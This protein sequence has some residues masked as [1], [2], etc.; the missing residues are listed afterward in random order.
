MQCRRAVDVVRAPCGV[1]PLARF[2]TKPALTGSPSMVHRNSP[3]RSWCAFGTDAALTRASGSLRPRLPYQMILGGAG[4]ADGSPPPDLFTLAVAVSHVVRTAIPC[5]SRSLCWNMQLL[6]RDASPRA[7]NS[8]LHTGLGMPA[9][10]SGGPL[11]HGTKP[12]SSV[13]LA[14]TVSVRTSPSTFRW[15]PSVLRACACLRAIYMRS[16]HIGAV[17][18]VKARA[19]EHRLS[20]NRLRCCAILLCA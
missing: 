8:R 4:A 11:S 1:W 13:P 12:L 7:H 19:A 6:L 10:R 16:T 18:A 2:T 20:A 14:S 17:G 15:N 5:V 9:V 3:S